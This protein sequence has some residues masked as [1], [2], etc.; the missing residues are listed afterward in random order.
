M[1]IQIVGNDLMKQ[2]KL[3]RQVSIA[4]RIRI[5]ATFEGEKTKQVW[6]TDKVQESAERSREE[7][8]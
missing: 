3:H 7:K 8:V 4:E 2:I 6:E 1:S 5:K